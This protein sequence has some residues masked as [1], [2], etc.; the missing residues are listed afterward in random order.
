MSALPPALG[1]IVSSMASDADM[2]ELIEM[3]VDEMGCR[4]QSLRSYMDSQN[5]KMLANEAHKIRGSAG[6]HGFEVIGGAAAQL[7]DNL[8]SAA[9]QEQQVV[10]N[11]KQQVDELIALCLRAK[12]K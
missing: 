5:W 10:Q 8:R 4:T 12:A 2:A 7:E 9:G 3:Y 11:V 1:P 6:G